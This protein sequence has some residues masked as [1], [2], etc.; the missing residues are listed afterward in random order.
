MLEEFFKVQDK[1]GPRVGE[2]E[3]RKGRVGFSRE[4]GSEGGSS[5]IN[6]RK[7]VIKSSPRGQRVLERI[8]LP[9]VLHGSLLLKGGDDS[10]WRTRPSPILRGTTP[11]ICPNL[12]AKE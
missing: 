7:Q 12:V 1:T 10:V 3:G 9:N 11:G 5:M 6:L 2:G 4:S 8:I